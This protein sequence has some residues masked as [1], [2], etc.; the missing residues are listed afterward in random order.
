MGG[1]II[2]MSSFQQIILSIIAGAILTSFL[3]L[4]K[5]IFKKTIYMKLKSL[6][7]NDL[8]TSEGL[9][10]VYA[11]LALPPLHNSNGIIITHPYVKP[12]EETSGIGFSIE[13]P[14]SSCELRAAKYL[15]EILGK[16]ARRTPSLSSD[17]DLY[18]NLN[19][20]FIAFGGPSSNYKSR[21]ALANENN[22][23]LKFGNQSFVTSKNELPVLIH[24]QGFDYGLIL[25]IHPTQFPNR[26]WL[27]CAGYGEWGSSGAAW[28]LS[29]KW[30]ETYKF[31]QNKPFA[32]VVKVRPGQD[33]SAESVVRIKSSADAKKYADSVASS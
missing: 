26:T 21:D 8:F 30:R 3:E 13:R 22:I 5:Y 10:L 16:E 2:D 27:I 15:A 11:K 12:G 18:D 4:G 31:A 28:Y 32:I 25:K 1:S 24:Q 9:H 33:E 17:L 6:F 29:H 23:F 7:G 14:V 19:I 20:S